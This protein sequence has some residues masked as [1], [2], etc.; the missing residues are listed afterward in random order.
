MHSGPY[1]DFTEASYR[2]LL[3][4]VGE[5]YQFGTFLE[6]P[7][8]PHAVWRH[9]I[10]LS[11]HRARSLARIEAEKGVRAT[12]FVRVR[13]P[14]Y[15][16]F[17]RSVVAILK[18]I[19]AMGHEIGLHVEPSDPDE[20]HKAVLE[21][22]LT[23]SV[24]IDSPVSVVSFHNPTVAGLLGFNEPMIEG[25][26]NTY[27]TK[28]FRE[29]AYVTDSGG[30]W[31]RPIHELLGLHPHLHVVTHP[32]WWTE[33]PMSPDARIRRGLNGRARAGWKAYSDEISA[34]FES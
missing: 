26:V 18:E 25:L 15:N 31:R 17:E 28:F 22:G 16:V 23:L 2:Q 24:A 14:F 5:L 6:Q 21:D 11:P 19:A 7:N 13:S 34:R 1:D 8:R 12:Y 33:A 32:E 4:D 29:Y 9:D 27:S 30:S 20:V 10:D 3:S